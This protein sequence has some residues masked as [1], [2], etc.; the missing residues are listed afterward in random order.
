MPFRVGVEQG[1]KRL[2]PQPSCTDSNSAMRRDTKNLVALESSQPGSAQN[3][4]GFQYGRRL[5]REEPVLFF[6]QFA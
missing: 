5:G 6:P 1:Q 3:I 2:P 4:D